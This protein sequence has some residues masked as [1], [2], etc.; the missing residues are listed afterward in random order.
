VRLTPNT[1][2]H[3]PHLVP[4]A[5]LLM[6]GFAAPGAAQGPS[7]AAPAS[8]PWGDELAAPAPVPS[9][10]AGGG[11]PL[12]AVPRLEWPAPP[13]EPPPHPV[14]AIYVNAWAFGSRRFYDLIRLV[15]GTEVNSF[16]IDVKD[17]TGYLTYRSAVSTAIGIG[18]NTQLRAPD[19]RA[20]LRALQARGIHPIARIVVA[21]DPL[22][23]RQRPGWAIHDVNGGSWLD[24]QGRPWV[25]AYTDSVWAYAAALGVEA[26]RLGFDELQF[27]YV[28]FPD[29]PRAR[30][31]TAVF[32]GQRGKENSEQGVTRG[33][34]LLRSRVKPLGVPFTIDVFGL[35]TSAEDDMGIGQKWESLVASADVVLP[36]VYPSHYGAGSYGYEQP[37]YEPYAIIRRAMEDAR[38]RSQAV[39]A[40]TEIRPYIQAFTLGPPRYTPDMVREQI[41]AAEELGI[42]GWVMW[43]PR[44]DYDPGYFRSV[45]APAE[46]VPAIP[47]SIQ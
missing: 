16:V 17:D 32:P 20:R 24:R 13:L 39:H 8:I 41:R 35:T 4:F 46:S 37:N 2:R 30:L 6:A 9:V 10:A 25:D 47:V 14:R 27:D 3:P 19:T 26:V 7:R 45:Q 12:Q 22:L 15:E 42:K 23:A 36:M 40:T 43:N 21:K 33:L 31:A 34:R 44:S 38:Q 11:F 29:E 5:A 1:R 18:A 28:R